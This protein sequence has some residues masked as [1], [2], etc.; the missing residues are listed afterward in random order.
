MLSSKDGISWVERSSGTSKALSAR[1]WIYENSNEFILGL[2][3]LINAV[4]KINNAYLIIRI[5]ESAEYNLKDLEIILPQSDK[6]E[7]RIGGNFYDDLN[8]ADLL[9]SYS[10]TTI[11]EALYSKKPV[12]LFGGTDRYRHLS[13]MSSLP[14][15]DNRSAVY[16]LSKDNLFEMIQEILKVHSNKPL[17]NLEVSKYI[18]SQEVPGRQEFIK[19]LFNE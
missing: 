8:E 3:L 16:H 13:G 18:W 6:Y 10:S 2:T 14:S 15:F 12:A 5:R 19:H 9:V 4:K 7:L 11:E 1:P 17:T